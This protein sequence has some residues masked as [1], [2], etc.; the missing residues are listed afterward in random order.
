MK[1]GALEIKSR[2]THIVLVNVWSVNNTKGGAERVF[3]D[4]A[5]ALS[6]RGYD[7]T[8]LYC[9]P[10]PGK[11]GFSFAKEVRLINSYKKPCFS[12]LY[13]GILRN[14]LCWRFDVTKR[15]L[16]RLTF[17]S[18]VRVSSLKAAL[19]RLSKADLFISYQPET[20]WL[21][22]DCLN[23]QTPIITMFHINPMQF[24]LHDPNFAFYQKAVA[25]SEILHVLLSEFVAET[26]DKFPNNKINVIPNVAPQLD[27]R[28]DLSQKTIITIARL[29]PQKRTTLLLEAFALLKDRF[30]EWKCVWYGE[31]TDPEYWT[32]IE[33]VV[34]DNGLEERVLFPGKTDGVVSKLQNASIF[35]FPS[36]YEGFG[37]ALAEA[38]AMGLPAV[39][40]KDCPAV[41]TLIKNES[42]GL[43]K[44]PTPE[45]YAEGLAKLMESEELRRKYGA[46]GKED[47]KAYSADSVWEAWDK[48]IQET[49]GR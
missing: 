14:L 44:D 8:A 11:P 43:L 18:K 22:R 21:L 9:D 6:Q 30:P 42:N 48:L 28:A 19:C 37:L 47:M 10:H 1:T 13:K 34:R 32:T 4:M 49:I 36:E 31:R 27:I 16:A 17:T 15:H 23:I 38:F 46:Q 40:C 24:F 25:S 5:N 33:Q 41:R 2:K 35:A 20:T 45:A 29:T 39:G 7:I 3:C 12:F 26:Q